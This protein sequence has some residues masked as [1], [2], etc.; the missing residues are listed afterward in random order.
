MFSKEVVIES[1]DIT[2]ND[3]DKFVKQQW[4]RQAKKRH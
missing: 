3:G 4:V 2:R 1:K